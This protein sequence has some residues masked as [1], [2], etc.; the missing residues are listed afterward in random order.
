[1]RRTTLAI[2][3]IVVFLVLVIVGVGT[4]DLNE[5]LFNGRML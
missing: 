3:F 2:I 4:G 5:I 1:L